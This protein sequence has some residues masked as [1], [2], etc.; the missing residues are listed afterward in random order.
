MEER[1]LY[2]RYKQS[3]ADCDTVPGTYDKATKSIVVIVP[4]GRM[5]KSGTRGKTYS[6]LWFDGVDSDGNPIRVCIKAIDLSHAI[7]RLPKE[8]PT[9]KFNI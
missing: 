4:D 3:Y 8:Y 6:H 1:M 9:V 7:A 5:K 2:R